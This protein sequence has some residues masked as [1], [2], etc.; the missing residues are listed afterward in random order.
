MNN[1][2]AGLNTVT[3]GMVGENDRVI[4]AAP[5]SDGKVHYAGGHAY[6]PGV[7][8]IQI[9]GGQVIKVSNRPSSHPEEEKLHGKLF[10]REK[11]R[12]NDPT[13]QRKVVEGLAHQIEVLQAKMD[14][15]EA[16][17]SGGLSYQQLLEIAKRIDPKIKGRIK[18]KELEAMVYGENEA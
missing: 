16:P 17:G 18:K 12:E 7:Q 6:K 3:S 1:P 5:S 11:P 8:T 2:A 4:N 14:T 10:Y 9:R 13:E 15:K